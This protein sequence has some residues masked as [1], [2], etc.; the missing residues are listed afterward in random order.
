MRTT[1]LLAV[2]LAACAAPYSTHEAATIHAP[3]TYSCEDGLSLRVRFSRDGAHVTLPS[4]EEVF[5]AEQR[6]DGS[7]AAPDHQF[8]ST[9]DQATWKIGPR[10]PVACRVQR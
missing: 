9:G 8:T 3:V 7:Y 2:L 5:L 6:A 10:V 4:G 1:P